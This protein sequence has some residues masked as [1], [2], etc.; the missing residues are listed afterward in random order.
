MQPHHHVERELRSVDPARPLLVYATRGPFATIDRAEI[1][2]G[3]GGEAVLPPL[4]VE[5]LNVVPLGA[6]S[7]DFHVHGAASFDSAI[8]D[9]DRVASF[10]AAGVDVV[11]ATDHDVV[12]NYQ[13]RSPLRRPVDWP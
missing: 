11:I 2:V 4:V 12:T 3:P 13:R 6:L 9:Q 7:G 5:S 10:L 1:V 8:P